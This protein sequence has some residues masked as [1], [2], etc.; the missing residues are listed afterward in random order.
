MIFRFPVARTDK[1]GLA[2]S[3]R[4]ARIFM[5]AFYPDE[6]IMSINYNQISNSMDVHTIRGTETDIAYVGAR[7]YKE[8]NDVRQIYYPVSGSEIYD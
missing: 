3:M 5:H 1:V 8:E 4:A 7:K 2:R 6:T